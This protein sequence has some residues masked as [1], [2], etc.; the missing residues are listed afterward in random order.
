[1]KQCIQL[2]TFQ[3]FFLPYLPDNATPTLW[4]THFG[5]LF[6]VMISE[7]CYKVAHKTICL[8]KLIFRISNTSIISM[9]CVQK[10]QLNYYKHIFTWNFLHS[11]TGQV[12]PFSVWTTLGVV[13]R[14]HLFPCVNTATMLCASFFT[15]IAAVVEIRHRLQNKLQNSYKLFTC[16]ALVNNQ[17]LC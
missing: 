10:S 11:N 1:M 14:N 5:D 13:T 3:P 8:L 7:P 9:W 17:R 2:L 15:S 12:K 6:W 4:Y 16:L